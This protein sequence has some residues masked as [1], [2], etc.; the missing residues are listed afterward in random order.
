MLAVLI[1]VA[2]LTLLERKVL[3]LAQVRIGP[4]KV[5]RWGLLQPAAD[6][7]KLFTNSV[8]VVGPINKFGFFIRPRLRI[9]LSLM[10]TI[11]ISM[12]NRGVVLKIGLIYFLML[13]RL[14]VY[15]LLGAG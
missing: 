10:F 12:S 15:P 2:F 7:I 11:L 6:A 13:L 1:N 3:G 5:G 4:N 14:N 9:F 8:T